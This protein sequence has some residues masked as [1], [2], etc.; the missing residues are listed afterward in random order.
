[1]SN[2]APV[3]GTLPTSK[4]RMLLQQKRPRSFRLERSDLGAA[5]QCGHRSFATFSPGQLNQPTIAISS[6]EEA[7]LLARAEFLIEQSDIASARL[8]LEYGREK[9]SIR[10]IF[11][12]AETYEN[13]T[14]R[15]LQAYGIHPDTEK[16]VELYALAAG[17]G[18]GQ[19]ARA[20]RSSHIRY[21][22]LAKSHWLSRKG[23]VAEVDR[24]LAKRVDLVKTCTE[25]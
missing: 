22:P 14:S 1:M 16:A 25:R 24:A 9:G 20:V 15:P 10:A 13:R 3:I 21:K 5:Q 12:L 18:I 6:E 11:M 19:S 2:T 17:A 8:L 7:R 23:L 4:A